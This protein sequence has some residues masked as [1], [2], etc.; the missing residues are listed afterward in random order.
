MEIMKDKFSLRKGIDLNYQDEGNH[1][2][3]WASAISGMEKVYANGKEVSCKRGLSGKSNHIF[4]I[5]NIN[6]KISFDVD[7]LTK[8]PYHCTLYKN[9]K[10]IRRK[11]ITFDKLFE[12][13]T[14]L[15]EYVIISLYFIVGFS[16]WGLDY[17]FHFSDF[18]VNLFYICYITVLVI[19][20]IL[21]VRFVPPNIED[22]NL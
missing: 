14:T 5:N 2:K 4:V 16:F 10:A 8:G 18:I 19:E 13:K 12:F 21:T 17:Y 11:T 22:I 9:G 15:P 20:L 7:S 1:I 3:V 6:Y